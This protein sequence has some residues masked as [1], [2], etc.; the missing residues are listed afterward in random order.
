MEACI[1]CGNNLFKTENAILFFKGEKGLYTFDVTVRRRKGIDLSAECSVNLRFVE[2]WRAQ[3]LHFVF[4]LGEMP[5]YH[6]RIVDDRNVESIWE[7]T[8]NSQH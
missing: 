6:R 5:T 4:N 7:T 8:T 1:L 2:E 3:A